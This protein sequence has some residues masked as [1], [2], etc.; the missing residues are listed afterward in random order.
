M[1]SGSGKISIA[2]HT[3]LILYVIEEFVYTI[4]VCF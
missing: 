2:Q 4:Q 1:V 3:I